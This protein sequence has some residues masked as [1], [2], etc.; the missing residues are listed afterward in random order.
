MSPVLLAAVFLG[1]L[2]ALLAAVLILVSKKFAVNEDPRLAQIN[3]ALPQYNCG[4]CGF[5][6]CSG[7]A[8]HMLESRDPNASCPPGGRKSKATIAAILGMEAGETV[9]MT[10]H[11]RCKGSNTVAKR[12]GAYLG[13]RDCLAADLVMGAEKVCPYGC[14]GL[15]NC[16]RVCQFGAISMVDGLAV[17]D[18]GRCVSCRNCVAACPRGLISMLPAGERVVID[19][20]SRDRGVPVKNYCTRGCYT[21]QICIKK[22]PEGAISLVNEVVVIDQAKCTRC[23]ICVEACPQHTINAYNC[24]VLPKATAEVAQ[25]AKEAGA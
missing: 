14:L 21:C 18:E 6:G 17:V 9:P 19:C 4:G 11:V 15:G 10:A 8:R 20:I 24:A 22:C 3:D 13:I 5:P 12:E 7:F 16:E 2:G 23:G 1:V 25:A